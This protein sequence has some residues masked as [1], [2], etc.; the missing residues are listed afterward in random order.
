M[1][2]QLPIH[3]VGDE[4]QLLALH[5]QQ[6]ERLAFRAPPLIRTGALSADELA[7]ALRA[8]DRGVEV[9]A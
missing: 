6:G 4:N 1:S 7:E 5:C 3:V 2:R 8:L 9:P